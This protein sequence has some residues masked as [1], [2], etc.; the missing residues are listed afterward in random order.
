MS[1]RRGISKG[2][3]GVAN[4]IGTE[5]EESDVQEANIQKGF[6]ERSDTMCQT[7][8]VRWRRMR[9]EGGLPD[10]A[11]GITG[12]SDIIQFL[13]LLSINVG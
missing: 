13:L 1:G 11:H 4:G 8:L 2:D 3:Q 5:L 9:T 12:N 10:L 7:P 6:Q